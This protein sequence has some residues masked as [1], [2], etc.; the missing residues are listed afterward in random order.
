MYSTLHILISTFAG[1]TN[2]KQQHAELL[3]LSLPSTVEEVGH[4]LHWLAIQ[5]VEGDA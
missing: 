5:R 3:S 2:N 4:Y 1:L